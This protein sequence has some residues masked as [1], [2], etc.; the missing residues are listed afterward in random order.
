MAYRLLTAGP[1]GQMAGELASKR[2]ERQASY[3]ERSYRLTVLK[4]KDTNYFSLSCY[5]IAAVS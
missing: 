4:A 2:H 1:E 3:Y 5:V